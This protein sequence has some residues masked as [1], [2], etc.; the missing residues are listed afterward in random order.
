VALSQLRSRFSS[1]RILPMTACLFAIVGVQP[2]LAQTIGPPPAKRR[3]TP[4]TDFSLGVFGQLTPVRTPISTTPGFPGVEIVQTTQGA[5]P[6]AGV[7]ATVHQSFKPWLGYNVNFGYSRFP[8]TTLS[9]APSS[10]MPQ[11]SL[12]RTPIFLNNRSGPIGMS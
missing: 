1:R 4:S 10:R 12:R 3:F 8:E 5:S 2:A 11:P 9:V 6:S 7:L